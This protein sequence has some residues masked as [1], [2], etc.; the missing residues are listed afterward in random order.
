M[1]T[2]KRTEG[3]VPWEVKSEPKAMEYVAIEGQIKYLM[4]NILTVIDAVMPEG[5]QKKS[6]KDLI[7]DKFSQQLNWIYE[8]CGYPEVDSTIERLR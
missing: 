4:G 8:L 3:I 1:K 6:T 5:E 2:I 7:K